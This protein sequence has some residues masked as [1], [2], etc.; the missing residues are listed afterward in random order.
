MYARYGGCLR[1][2]VVGA[3]CVWPQELPSL[4][5]EQ[6]VD[7]SRASIFGHSMGGHGALTIGLK[8]PVG[9]VA[10]SWLESMRSLS[11]LACFVVCRICLR[12]CQRLRLSVAPPAVIGGER[13]WAGISVT[14]R[15]RGRS[16]MQ[17]N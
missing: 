7:T 8:N 14:T 11:L 6:D 5:A 4:L 16:M 1:V 3:T 15:R 12:R 2:T 10:L 13:R 17:R 9:G